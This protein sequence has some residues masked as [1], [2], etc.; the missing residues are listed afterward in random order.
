MCQ[1]SRRKRL[2]YEEKKLKLDKFIDFQYEFDKEK[3]QSYVRIS[4]FYDFDILH[5]YVS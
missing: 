2:Y 3:F 4:I 1:N 5:C